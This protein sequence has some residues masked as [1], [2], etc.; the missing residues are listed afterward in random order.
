PGQARPGADGAAPGI[1]PGAAWGGHPLSGK[2]SRVRALVSL[3]SGLVRSD[4]LGRSARLVGSGHRSSVTGCGH[5]PAAP[6]TSDRARGS[7]KAHEKRTAVSGARFLLRHR[8]LDAAL[9]DL[10]DRA[11]GHGD[12]APEDALLF[13]LERLA[14][15]L[16]DLSEPLA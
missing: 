5:L 6:I 14:L 11:L 8:H 9:F 1:E 16:D 10:L 13:H 15:D 2:P 4:G 7:S 12:L 3:A